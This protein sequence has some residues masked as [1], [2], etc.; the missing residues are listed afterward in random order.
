M[1]LDGI[2]RWEVRSRSTRVRGRIALSEKGANAIVGTCT[3]DRVEGPL[4]INDVLR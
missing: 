3:L 4:T 2:K 1:I